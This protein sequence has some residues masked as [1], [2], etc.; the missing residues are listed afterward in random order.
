MSPGLLEAMTRSLDHRGPDDVG[1]AICGAVGL[2]A[3][4]LA[5]RD[6]TAAGHMPF[7]SDDGR[8]SM[9]FNGELYNDH[10]LRVELSDRGH[11][12]RS[13]SDTEVALKLFEEL[14]V[15]ALSR[16]RGMFALAIYDRR[17]SELTVARDPYGIKPL[18]YSELPA[19][20]AFASELRALLQQ[21]DFVREIDTNA[22]DL[23]A[24]LGFV[25]APFTIWREAKRMPPGHYLRIRDGR[26]VA[27]EPYAK[28]ERHSAIDNIGDAVDLL[29]TTLRDSV[30]AHLI[31]DTPVAVFLS[32][33]IDSSLIAALALR[34]ARGTV[35]TITIAFPDISRS[36]EGPNARETA[37]ALGTR[38]TEIAVDSAEAARAIDDVLD[39][40]DEPFADPALIPSTIISRTTSSHFKVALSG[41]GGDELFGGYVRYGG[42]EYG[43]VLRPATTLIAIIARAKL[44]GTRGGMFE[45]WLARTKRLSMTAGKSRFESHLSLMPTFG[46]GEGQA[47]DHVLSADAQVRR[48]FMALYA[49]AE[50]SGLSG[51]NLTL[52]TDSRYLLPYEMLHKVDVASMRYGLEVR[53]PF[54]DREVVAAA[55]RIKPE[56][57]LRALTGKWILRQVAARYLPPTALRRAK[58]GFDVPV[59]EWLRQRRLPRLTK[60]LEECAYSAD[61]VP[62]SVARMHREHMA[63]TRDN[64]L[65][66]WNA[67]VFQQWRHRWNP[68]LKGD[69]A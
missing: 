4:R 66:L 28:V 12:F 38:H 64:F 65:P 62:G 25:P 3:T 31:A 46:I 11:E 40:L 18:F 61:F 16:L 51:L 14:G 50:Q 9:V 34:A 41:D 21:T 15:G 37:A 53:V 42:I 36:N 52:H 20:F 48:S 49:E 59:G 54:V 10:E 33:G 35:N 13:R 19:R 7:A 29:D 43:R 22:A 60:L 26:V 47:V 57:K 8:L 17:T 27:L 45:P 44:V 32:G 68:V 55:F 67:L 58:R 39:H 5:I 24:R 30:S 63:G 69:M 56:W 23:Y 2:G 6:L 1:T